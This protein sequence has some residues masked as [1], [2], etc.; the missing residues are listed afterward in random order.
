MFPQRPTEK[1]IIILPLDW[2]SNIFKNL[3]NFFFETVIK[4]VMSMWP[5]P[6]K[7]SLRIL[8]SPL[9]SNTGSVLLSRN[10]NT[11]ISVILISS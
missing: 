2:F 10:G 4:Y 8:H 6:K 7:I 1:S 11:P 9:L 5:P 3:L